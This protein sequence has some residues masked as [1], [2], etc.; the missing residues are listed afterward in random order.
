MIL[1]NL[2]ITLLGVALVVWAL[3]DTAWP[4]D[5]V[6]AFPSDTVSHWERLTGNDAPEDRIVQRSGGY[7][8]RRGVD[9]LAYYMVFQSIVAIIGLAWFNDRNMYVL[10]L[11]SGVFGV[12][13]S[14]SLGITI[15]PLIAAVG[16]GLIL[17]SG[18]LGLY[19][20]TDWTRS[21]KQ[22]QSSSIGSK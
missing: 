7:A 16:Y 4:A 21:K 1:A 20:T 8:I 18:V 11:I 19:S 6:S 5:F 3:V 10:L 15:G 17:W 12:A 9:A 14:A 22:L 13:Y 2:P